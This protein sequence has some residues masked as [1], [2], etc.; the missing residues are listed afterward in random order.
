MKQKLC[1]LLLSASMLSSLAV[2]AFA[3]DAS[4]TN[5]LPSQ[6]PGEDVVYLGVEN[7]GK[8]TKDEKETFKHRFFV[9]GAEKTF[10]IP[11][12]GGKFEIQNK[13]Q[14]GYIYDVT[15]DGDQ[16]TAAEMEEGDVAG[17][18]TKVWTDDD[19]DWRIKVDNES[20]TINKD[21]E[22]YDITSKAGGATVQDIKFNELKQ[23]ETVRI[24]VDSDDHVTKLFRMFIA[25]DYTAPVSG[26]PGKQTL[27]NFL[28]TALTPV[29]TSLYV[30]GGS[31]D[32]QDVN[33][34]NQAMTI[35]LSQ[36]W[37]D[38]F[39]SQ[40]ANYTYK[41]SANPSES[42]YPH[43]AWNQYY[44]AGIDCS[45][46]VGWS[47]YNVMNTEDSTVA[48]NT[49]YV[50]SAT[51]QAKNF[52]EV[53]KWGTWSQEKPF[54]PEHF[55]TGDIFSMNGHV[56]ICLGKCEDGSLVILHSTP[57]DSINGQGG[58]GVQINGV[59]ES[60]DCQAVKLAEEYMSKYYPQW[61]DRYH[62]VYKNFDN[63]TKYEGENAG[64]FSWDLKNTLADPDG[65]AN[66]SADEILADLFDTYH[67]EA[68]YL[69]VNGYGDRNTNWDHKPT[70]QHQFFVDG[71]VRTFTVNDEKDY[72]LQNQL[73][74]GY[75]YDIDVTANE[76]TDVE[77]KDKGHSNV[78]MGEVTA[79]GNDTITVD[80]KTLNTAN[81]K[82]YEITSKA[83]GSS[84]KDATVKVGDTVKVMVNGDQAKTVYKTF[85]AEEY[86]A[87]VSGT[88]GEKTL[89]N[90][91]A[92]AL[93]PVGTSL[94]VYGGSW[95]W[96]DVNSSNQAMTIGLS[97]S[98]IDFFQSQDANYTY[99]YN[100]DHSESYYP[101]E[102]WNQ[103]YYAG[104]D[105]SAF[106]GWS[107]YNTMHTTNGSVANG[108]KGYVMSATQ[109][110]KNF[111]NEQGWGTWEQ[112]APFKPEDFKTGDIFSMNGHVW[113]CLGKCE[114]GSLVIL[115]STPS[116]SIN[117]Q[118][119]GGVQINGVGDSEDCQAVKLAE[120]YMSKYYPQW[121][122]RYHKVYKNFKDYTKYSGDAAGK[123]SWNLN[124]I[125]TDTEGY[126]SMS[127]DQILADLFKDAKIP[128]QTMEA[129]YLG[130][131]NYGTVTSKEKESFKHRFFIDGDIKT[132]TIPADGGKFEIQN[133]LQEGYIYDITVKDEA[134]VVDVELKDKDHNDVVMGEVTAI[135]ENTI[136]VNGKTLNTADSKTYEITS[137]AGG[138]SV[139]AATVAVSDTVKVMVNGDQAETVYKA[140]V[141]EEYKAPVSGTPGKKTLKN[142]LA[143]AMEPVGTALYVYGGTWDWQDVNSSN[144]SM[145]IGLSQSWIDFF[146]S[147]DKTY[148]YK[149]PNP[150]E[151][152]YPHNAWN[153]YYYA[154][155]D[156]SG[157][158][159]WS[160]YN[161]MNT[162]NSTVA[163]NKGYVMSATKQ[164]GV[165][166]SNEGWGTMDMGDVLMDETTGKPWVDEDGDGRRIYEGHEFKPGDIFS[167]NGHVWIS[168]GTCK[169]GS[170]VFMHSTPNT[171]NGAGVQISA[172]GPNKNCEA[173]KLANQYMNKYFPQWSERY[174]DQVLCLTFDSYT[175]VYGDYA[176]KFSWNLKNGVISDPDGYAD[177]TPAEILADLFHE[178]TGS[179]S[180]GSDHSDPT[181]AIRASAGKG[182]SI[183]PKGTVRVEKNDSKTYTI[184]AD[185]GYAIA[186]VT[187]NG[188]SVGAVDSYTFKNV[189]SDQ[190][191]RATFALEGAAEQPGFSDVSKNDWFYDAVQDAVD[192]G[193]MAGVSADRFDPKGTVTRAMVA[194]ILYARE[195][196]PTVSGAAA[197]SDVPANAWF[198]N[199]MQWA[200]GQGVIAGYPDGRMDPNAPV[201]REQLAVI[202][203]SYAQ[204]KGMNVSKTADLS[205]YADSA[206]VS[207]WAKDAM[208]W[209]VGSGLISGRSAT[210]LAP[211]GSATRAECAVIFTQMFQK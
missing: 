117:G 180:G 99:K 203:H 122:E 36:S 83:G 28:A 182:G 20:F 18:L 88:P 45:A 194:Q 195:G 106:V 7:Y 176:G 190:T 175:K 12:D 33:S 167:M 196:K 178:N 201:T 101:H 170:I 184:T 60:K 197:I 159:G 189:T 163:D 171:T 107:V 105:C 49:G 144:Q 74:E 143:T 199:A 59:G 62:E 104:I 76:V 41:N 161:L 111:A 185:K 38:F 70:F 169:D 183:S 55:Q 130:V 135:G 43:N 120:E 141:A 42:Y 68:V 92:T 57:S 95:D 82:T 67:G 93:T 15:I 186:D 198:H 113:I 112:K 146:Q 61:W 126:A 147:Q 75:V 80:G 78:V 115:H 156:C 125:L 66:M 166:A 9:D 71:D 4:E 50:M 54:K 148:H 204:K 139:K 150:A 103:Y 25:E 37:I 11:A 40:D 192:M 22:L 56:W 86:K 27:K 94:Y 142:F 97:Q 129:V 110:A 152:Y 149:N 6:T 140:F 5:A 154:G 116:D 72:S 205:G 14:E 155:I 84:V 17:V 3:V 90:F 51:K 47:V 21:A 181:Y 137:K 179:S 52:A 32:W 207:V 64:K 211:A 177:M 13:L 53:Q 69:G 188:K 96:Q 208:S 34:S 1:A 138:S 187:V 100:A 91:L 210:T 193:L 158:V 26:V 58:G 73:M 162:E 136:T 87:P 24:V 191:I 145:T 134:Q 172:I 200:K 65:Y 81:A 127:A 102:Q 131:E 168:L 16:I 209:A 98:W 151:S 31:W 132:Y 164:A 39:Q 123:F 10:T 121:W 79:I 89:K 35:G 165:F 8:V 133:Q 19:G 173:Y 2:P 29:G 108:D 160:V 114:D 202:L 44:Y 77:L 63:Y 46:F 48:D 128:Q 124:G 119:G 153:Q 157:Y 85:V 30:Y 118:G 109:Q 23:N 174:G 206:A